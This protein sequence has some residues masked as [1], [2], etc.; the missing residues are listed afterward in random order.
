MN[1][2]AP[3]FLL[4][5]LAVALPVVFHLIRR[6]TRERTVFSSL[7]FLTPTPP[8]LTRRSR[9]EHL[10]LLLLRCAVILVLALGF[11][12]PFLKQ[13][14]AAPTVGGKRLLLLVDTSASMRRPELW[15]AARE[16]A[17]ALLRRISPVDQA[18]V[19]TFDRQVVPLVTFEQW[20]AAS[21]SERVALASGKLAQVHPGWAAT[22]LGQA[23]IRAAETLAD[24]RGKSDGISGEIALI[25]DLQEGC[26]P[27][28]LQG[29][30]W[31]KNVQ[32][33]V[34]GLKPRVAGNA[35][36]QWV[37]EGDETESGSARAVRLRISNSAGSRSE[38]FKLNWMQAG[39]TAGGG[40]GLEVY[41]PAGQ[42]RLVS[43]PAPSAN[44]RL[45]AVRL[46][47]DEADFDNTVYVVPPETARL[48]V[49]YSGAESE[50][51][52]KQS[53][54]FLRRAFQETRR[55]AVQVQV[56][57]P[58]TPVVPGDT[59]AALWVVVDPGSAER[60][61]ALRAQAEAGKTL[62][63]VLGSQAAGSGLAK[64]LGLDALTTEEARP[65][66]YAMLAEIDFQHP[67]F[68][69]FADARF[70]DFTKIHF[71]KYR[72]VS[73]TAIP[74]ARVVARFD[75][76]DPALLEV[77]MGKGRVL[78]LTSS[79]LARRQP[80][81]PFHQVCAAHVFSARE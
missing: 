58:E 49:L 42:S 62:L 7:L 24:S 31:P 59:E 14:V 79:W 43:L 61:R 36:L 25:S 80:I 51:D 74:G 75:S 20:T 69:P 26:H 1:F 65:D 6:T 30:E 64:L 28:P 39:G 40:P 9:L 67:L 21:Q 35:A 10:L 72:R 57:L 22:Q 8:R 81:G 53:L 54:Y 63:Y 77:P 23:L 15:A 38:N 19:F 5:G 12:R 27:E 44:E 56:R 3:L 11:A 66:R 2:L 55:Q 13:T 17:E 18:A 37:A 60:S 73:A 48:V 68:I 29:Y 46:Q 34:Y 47:G 4:G 45:N 16:Q 71:W 50:S 70:S 76:G 41:V 32:V 33:T 52:P 78:I